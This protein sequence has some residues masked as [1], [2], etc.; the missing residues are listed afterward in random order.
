MFAIAFDMNIANFTL[1]YPL[2]VALTK[3]SN[4]IWQLNGNVVTLHPDWNNHTISII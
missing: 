3:I 4:N 1:I 2:L